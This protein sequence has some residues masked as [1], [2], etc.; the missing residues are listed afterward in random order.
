MIHRSMGELMIF[1]LNVRV[2]SSL[3][4]LPFQIFRMLPEPDEQHSSAGKE[5]FFAPLT[6]VID[7]SPFFLK[8]K[9]IFK[10]ENFNQIQ[11]RKNLL[12]KLFILISLKQWTKPTC[13]MIA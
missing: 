4:A 2:Q 11:G 5:W 12:M 6:S 13:R 10:I 9:I 7:L 8:R 3:P 1:I